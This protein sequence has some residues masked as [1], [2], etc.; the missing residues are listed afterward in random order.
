MST[1]AALVEMTGITKRYGG[2][3]ACDGVDLTVR[4][5][6]VHALLGENGAG[7]STLMRVLS[8]DIADY[9]GSV[10]IEGRQVRFGKPADA[11]QA[12]IA[13]IHQ[14]LD[15][16]PAL[17]V[18]ENLYLGRELR[19]RFGGVDRRRMAARTRELLKRTGIDLDPARAVGELRVGEQQLVT[20]ARALLL[21]AKVLIMDEPTSAL[22]NTEVERLFA[23][24]GE[25]RRR[26]TGVVY[27]SHR[28]DEIGQIADRA[29]V[30]RNGRWVAEFDARRVTA[31]QAAEAMVGREVQTMFRTGKTEI[32]DEL[33]TLSGF[34][35][36][37]RRPRVGRREPDGID[38]TVR[39][40][41]IVGLCGLLG[42]GRTELLE[43]LFGAGSPGTWEGTVTLGGRTVRPRGPRQALR[44]GIA[45]VPEDRRAAG[46]VLGHSVMANT[47]LSVVDRLGVGGLVRRRSEVSTTQESVRRLK[48]KLGRILD[49]VGTLSGG[50]QQK[51]VFGRM[52]LTE[53]RLLLL[54]DPTRGVDIGAKAEIYQLL[55]D[56]AAQGIGVL[57]ASSELPEL[58][59]VCSRVVVLRGGR[60]VAEFRTAE[61]GEAELLA[62]AMGE[63]VSAGGGDAAGTGPVA[64]G[65]AR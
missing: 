56:I 14:E 10:A 13:M 4:A 41:E 1:A 20:I 60:S 40:G 16:V 46:L 61:T 63:R 39:A 45:F 59:G 11:Q 17:S 52:L 3:V 9:E 44:E 35:V 12:G 26:G 43:T 49:P 22:S 32:G 65:G 53:P 6:E 51:V 34:A 33:L 48:V 27:I 30:L 31:E 7:K 50:N 64:G 42:S 55:S 57:L 36:R 37:P 62:A 54:D 15:L 8:G 24:I 38:L 19:N 5:G 2:V 58:V 25:L 23:V 47:V 21:D 29:T 28:M 18:A